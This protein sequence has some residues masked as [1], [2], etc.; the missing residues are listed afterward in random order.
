MSF[1]NPAKI[2]KGRV[3]ELEYEPFVADV[4]ANI[5]DDILIENTDKCLLNDREIFCIKF[6]SEFPIN[7]YTICIKSKDN[8]VIDLNRVFACPV[9]RNSSDL[10][11]EYQYEVIIKKPDNNEYDSSSIKI[12]IIAEYFH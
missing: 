12:Y 6:Y 4:S 9:S 8:I 5:D 1:C 2:P 3:Y 10:K 7:S 11:F